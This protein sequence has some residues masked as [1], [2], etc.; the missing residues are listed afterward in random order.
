M[1]CSH[2]RSERN[3]WRECHL[4]ISPRQGRR[5]RTIIFHPAVSSIDS[6]AVSSNDSVVPPGQ[7]RIHAPFHGFRFASPV[8]TAPRPFGAHLRIEQI[9][10]PRNSLLLPPSANGKNDVSRQLEAARSHMGKMKIEQVPGSI[11]SKRRDHIRYRFNSDRQ[12]M[13]QCRANDLHAYLA[14]FLKTPRRHTS[15]N[16]HLYLRQ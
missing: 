7:T 4:S 5:R 1:E 3:P 11:C 2:G 12:A 14:L 16:G 15:R 13:V 9:N 8:A 10:A 6:V